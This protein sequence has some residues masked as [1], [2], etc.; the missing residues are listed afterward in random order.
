MSKRVVPRSKLSNHQLNR[1]IEFFALE[2]SAV[3]AAG[4]LGIH[5]HSAARVYRAIRQCMAHDCAWHT[6][7]RATRGSASSDQANPQAEESQNSSWRFSASSILCRTTYRLM[8]S[9][10][11]HTINTKYPVDQMPSRSPIHLIQK[12]KLLS[13]GATR[14]LLDRPHDKTHAVFGWD[15]H[16]HVHMIFVDPDL[17]E[18]LVRA[19]LPSVS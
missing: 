3:K 13:H 15:H 7:L 17:C 2:V 8:I 5:R 12:P 10:A 14:V 4:V 19:V 9:S 18:I 6:P 11:I 1:L 16:V